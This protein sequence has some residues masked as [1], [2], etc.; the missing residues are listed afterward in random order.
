MIVYCIVT[1]RPYVPV[2]L[3][4][5]QALRNSQLRH[6][7]HRSDI[8]F[9]YF[10]FHPLL[11]RC[12]LTANPNTLSASTYKSVRVFSLNYELVMSDPTASRTPCYSN[13]YKR[14][15]ENFFWQST[16][17]QLAITSKSIYSLTLIMNG[18]LQ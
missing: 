4:I 16:V 10:S 2:Q 9:R 15:I 3:P 14:K 17:Y 13:Q 8:S 18:A 6:E 1:V 7:R 12:T 5:T 11:P